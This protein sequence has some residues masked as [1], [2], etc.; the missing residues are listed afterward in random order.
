[1]EELEETSERASYRLALES[2]REKELFKDHK[3]PPIKK[4]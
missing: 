2:A 3:K 1:M 4:V